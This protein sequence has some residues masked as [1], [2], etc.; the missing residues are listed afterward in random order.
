MFIYGICVDCNNKKSEMKW[1]KNIF[2]QL[3]AI[4]L[5]IYLITMSIRKTYEYKFFI[6]KKY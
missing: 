6:K 5:D 2:I 3:L 4:K 1:K